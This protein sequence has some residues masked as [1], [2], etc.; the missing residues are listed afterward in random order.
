M[1]CTRCGDT[2]IVQV[3]AASLGL[4]WLGMVQ[5]SCPEPVHNDPDSAA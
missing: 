1:K 4:G 3:Q 5:K 2:G